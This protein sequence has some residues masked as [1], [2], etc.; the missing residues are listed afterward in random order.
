MHCVAQDADDFGGKHGLKDCDCLAD[1]AAITRRHVTR[2][3]VLPG[4]LAQGLH[5][6]EKRLFRALFWHES[7][8]LVEVRDN[9]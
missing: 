2:L 4:A 7:L 3:E 8:H 1:I 5:I 9:Q 6:S